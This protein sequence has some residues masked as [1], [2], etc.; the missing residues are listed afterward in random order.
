MIDSINIASSFIQMFLL[1]TAHCIEQAIFTLGMN[2]YPPNVS[3]QKLYFGWVY[4]IL[5]WQSLFR[6]F[7]QKSFFDITGIT[8]S[9]IEET[10]DYI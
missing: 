8:P 1:I 4:I 3:K 7:L 2:V 9:F 5:C 10:F 6:L